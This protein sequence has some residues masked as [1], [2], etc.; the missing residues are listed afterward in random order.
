MIKPRL[1]S[2][3]PDGHSLFF[4]PNLTGF[5]FLSSSTTQLQLVSYFAVQPGGSGSDIYAHPTLSV[6]LCVW[7]MGQ[8]SRFGPDF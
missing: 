1:A 8:G 2:G 4:S 5:V 7:G 3:S 6:E